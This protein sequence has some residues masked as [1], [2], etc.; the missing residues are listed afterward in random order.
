MGCPPDER[1]PEVVPATN[2]EFIS[3]TEAWMH[4]DQLEERDPKYF[5]AYDDAP[6]QVKP[7]D[8]PK[9]LTDD[10]MGTGNTPVMSAL[11]P[12]DTIPWEHG[13]PMDNLHAG[14][15]AFSP[16]EEKEPDEKRICGLRKKIFFLGLGVLIIIVAAS[17]GGGVGGGLA[18]ASARERNAAGPNPTPTNAGAGSDPGTGT[19][20]STSSAPSP[21]ITDLQNTTAKIQYKFQ[22][23][24]DKL[25]QGRSTGIMITSGYYDLNISAISYMWVPEKLQPMPDCC[26]TFCTNRTEHG[27]YWC[28]E[29]RQ[30]ETTKGPFSRIWMGCGDDVRQPHKCSPE[31]PDG[32]GAGAADTETTMAVTDP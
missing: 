14:D 16:V 10:G 28:D 11:S 3:P 23:W 25:Y 2:P 15:A 21:T 6:M 5:V 24:E 13:S 4:G 29:K 20:S 26:I 7:D 31:D 8:A 27:G 12:T 9:I 22:A 32:T 19:G 18:A 1:L 30:P 17:V